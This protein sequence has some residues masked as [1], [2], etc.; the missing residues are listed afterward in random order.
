MTQSTDDPLA[1][2]IPLVSDSWVCDTKPT[3]RVEY[4]GAIPRQ[5]VDADTDGRLEHYF[6][7]CNAHVAHCEFGGVAVPA[8]TMLLSTRCGQHWDLRRPA[9]AAP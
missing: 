5:P 7:T 8:T 3:R 2:P 1:I 9:V 6:Y 4:Y